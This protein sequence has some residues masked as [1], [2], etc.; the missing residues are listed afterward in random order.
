MQRII[1]PEILDELPASDPD[2]KKARRDLQRINFW[3]GHAAILTNA[4][5]ENFRDQPPLTVAEL[6]AGDGTLLLRIATKLKNWRG[7]EVTFV[8]RQPVVSGQT[9]E[10]FR[11]L[12]WNV[13]V[14]AADVFEW[15]SRDK[16]VDCLFAN[17]FVH[18]FEGRQLEVLMREAAEKT[19]FFAACEPRRTEQNVRGCRLLWLIGCGFVARNDAVISVRA[20]FNGNE[21]TRLWPQEEKWSLIERQG[22]LFSHLFVAK[23]S[24]DV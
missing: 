18:H 20:G 12:D 6:G 14:E 7:V 22:G 1:E 8:D 4:L 2:A 11:R 9:I 15:L 17:L 19:K 24:P 13:R 10:A 23:R 5:R 16:K 21:L 3:M